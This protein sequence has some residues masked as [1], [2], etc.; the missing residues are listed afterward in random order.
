MWEIGEQLVQILPWVLITMI[1][2]ILTTLRLPGGWLIVAEAVAYGW[3]T[4]WAQVGWLF[5]GL[6]VVLAAVGEALEMLTSVLTARK[7]GAGRRAAWGGFIGGF[8]GMIFLSFLVPMPVLGSLCGAILGCFAGATIGEITD[9]RQ[10]AQGTRAG[11]FSAIGFVIG[12][13]A[14]LI[15]SFVMAGTFLGW[16]TYLELGAAGPLHESPTD[17]TA[18]KQTAQAVTGHQS[19]ACALW[20]PDTARPACRILQSA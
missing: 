8:L 14:K 13:V 9:K 2:L 7:A 17:P 19:H 3:W 6:F 11:F 5:V 1:A 10:F 12:T 4:E 18:Q 15:V 16:I 20:H